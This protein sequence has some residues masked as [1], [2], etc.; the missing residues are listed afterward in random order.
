MPNFNVKLKNKKEVAEG[1]AAFYFQ[2]PLHFQF[3]PGQFVTMTLIDPPATDS[4]GNSRAFTI[5]S[6]PWETDLMIA[7]RMRDTAFKRV[8]NALPIGS[9]VKIGGPFGTLLLDLQSARSVV[10]LAGGIGITPFKSMMEYV[11]DKK[12][13][14]DLKLLYSNKTPELIAYKKELDALCE[15]NPNFEAAYTITR[16][17]ESKVAW[18]GHTGRINED[19]IRKHAPDYSKR[20][21]YLCA[22]DSM[23]AGML[24]LLESMGVEKKRVKREVFTGLH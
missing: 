9:D 17:E 20:L 23:V 4:E 3:K 24:T 22:G 6:A 19:F 10:F 2:K 14:N 13:P 18:T 8:L 15:A 7:T 1:T 5:A 11:A 12:L 16:P 21:W